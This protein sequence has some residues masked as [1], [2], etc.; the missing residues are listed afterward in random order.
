M[1]MNNFILGVLRE[2][3]VPPPAIAGN[4]IWCESRAREYLT[5]ERL[6]LI[7]VVALFTRLKN[8]IEIEP[9]M[10]HAAKEVHN[11]RLR[12]STIETVEYMQYSDGSIDV[13]SAIHR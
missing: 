12:P 13:A 10:Y 7:S 6:H 11:H 1:P 9:L 2:K 5:S 8:K 4:M 3:C